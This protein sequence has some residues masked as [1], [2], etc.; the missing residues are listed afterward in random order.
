MIPG[1]S[2]KQFEGNIVY[3]LHSNEDESKDDGELTVAFGKNAL[4]I[5]FKEKDRFDKTV[6]LI[7]I[8][9]GKIYTLDTETKTFTSRR[10]KKQENLPEQLP[11]K[12]IAGYSTSAIKV[13]SNSAISALTG[14]FRLRDVVFYCSD[15]LFYAMPEKY[16][17]N[18]ELAFL[19]KGKIILGA[20]MKPLNYSMSDGDE[21]YKDKKDALINILIEAK[22]VKWEEFKDNEFSIPTDYIKYK[23]EIP[24]SDSTAVFEE[25]TMNA[26]DSV[27]EVKPAETKPV[28]KPPVNKKQP[29][30]PKSKTNGT[31]PIRKPE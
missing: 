24:A 23:N 12:K 16:A 15:S 7:R 30:K 17:S 6:L 20:E 1:F 21:E 18:A 3:N 19:H 14:I 4:S 28:K 13:G 27:I 2:Q 22:S 29:A 10:M 8:D 11:G 31:Q 26:V 25:K 5:K 9:S